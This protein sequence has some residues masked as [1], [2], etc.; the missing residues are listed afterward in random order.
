MKIVIVGGGTAGWLSALFLCKVQKGSHDVTVIES[1]KIGIIG[2]GEGSTGHLADIV[3]NRLWNFDCN[4]ADF[5]KECDVTL[6]LGIKHKAWT[7]DLSHSYIG[8]IDGSHTGG[9]I[10]DLNFLYALGHKDLSKLHTCTILGNFIDQ[11]KST[12]FDMESTTGNHAYHFDAHKVGKYFKK[13]SALEGVK[14]IDTE[15]KEVMLNEQGFIR[16]LKLENGQ[17]IEGDFFIDCSGFARVLMKKLEAKWIS[18]REHLPV[19]SAMPFLMPYDE[20]EK[21][22]PLTT[23]WAQNNGWMWQIPTLNRY[24]CGYVFDSNFVSA[25]QAQAELEKTIGKKIDPIRVLKFET[26]RL[27]NVWMKNCV[28]VGLSAAFAEP[29]E[30]TSIHSTI[31]Q[32]TYL[33]FEYLRDTFDETYSEGAASA[34]SRRCGYMYDTFKDFLVLH[35]MGGR[36][37]TEFWKYISSGATLTPFV[38]DM[39]DMSKHRSPNTSEFLGFFGYAGWVLFSQVLAGTNNLTPEIARKELEFYGKTELAKKTYEDLQ[40]TYIRAPQRCL[41]NTEFV[42]KLQSGSELKLSSMFKIS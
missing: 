10:P 1:S 13:I 39:L 19:D 24:G 16:S 29:L 31:V 7:P 8:P 2:A 17:E 41:D 32:L 5:I 35:Y 12:Y 42:R 36:Q 34:Y 3:N 22:E 30:A 27:E 6:K 21:I 40:K 37:D 23:A 4:E 9:D 26:G 15:V 38:K 14:D 25:D 33:T 11:N 28:A 18:Y 20:N